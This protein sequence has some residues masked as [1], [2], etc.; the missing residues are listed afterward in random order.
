MKNNIDV[1]GLF[2]KCNLMH[3]I[4]L[5]EFDFS[6]ITDTTNMFAD[7]TSLT[8]LK[9][10]KNLKVSL[11]LSDCPLTHESALS[12]ID[13]LAVV[14]TTDYSVLLLKDET[15]NTLS[16]EDIKKATDKNWLIKTE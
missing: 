14:N 7:C 4:N 11:D 2:Y 10:G 1:R 13:G 6:N 8:N 5:S 9:F 12:A 3:S 15:Y 16:K